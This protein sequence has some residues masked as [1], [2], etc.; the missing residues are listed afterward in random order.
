MIKGIDLSYANK[1]V[2]YN[3]LKQDG[4]EFAIIRTGYGK[5]ENQKDALFETHYAGLK[6]AGIKVGAYLYS[7]CTS[8][9]NAELEA[10]N[11]LKHI[12]GKQFDLPIYLDLEEARTKVLGIDAVTNIAL[13]FCRRIKEAGYRAGIYANLDWY[14]NNIR[15]DALLLENFSI[16]LAQW[17]D[18]ITANFPVDIWQYTNN[19]NGMDGDYIINDNI[20]KEKSCTCSLYGICK[21]DY[22]NSLAVKVIFG[23]YGNGEERKQKLGA[24]YNEV[25][26]IVNKLYELLEERN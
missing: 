3:K 15:P 24:K 2:D 12:S 23:E 9:E 7:Y 8:I 1:N 17:N 16:W 20:I 10:E 19:Y 11:C 13:I 25:Q 4:I 14:R 5:D 6:Q 26:E 21:D 18:K 22:I